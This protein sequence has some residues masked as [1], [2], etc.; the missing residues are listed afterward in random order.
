MI[1]F[2]TATFQYDLSNT[3]ISLAE[4]NDIFNDDIDRNYTLPFAIKGDAELLTKLGIPTLENISD[5]DTKI[6]GRLIVGDNHYPATL[7]L[8]QIT[9]KIIECNITFGEENISTYDTDLKDL[10]WP[11]NVAADILTFARSKSQSN[12]PY[13]AFAFPMIYRPE[14]SKETNYDLFEGFVNNY[15]NG[16]YLGNE[17][18]T[19]GPEPV[20]INRNVLAPCPY[21]LEILKFGFK[22]AG[23]KVIGDIFKDEVLKKAVYIPQN[24][25]E[26]FRGSEYVNFSFGMPTSTEVV[27]NRIVYG[28]YEKKI[29]PLSQGTY[30]IDYNINLD[31]VLARYF[32]F[33]IFRE[34]SLSQERTILFQALSKDNRVTLDEKFSVNVEELDN[35]SPIIIQ[36]KILQTNQSITDFNNFEYS[37]KG[38]QLNEFPSVFTLSNFMPDQT[39]GEFVNE[40]K[41]WLNLDITPNERYVEI[42]FT[43]DSILKKPS[44]DHSHL[45][46]PDKKITHNSN[47]F[48]KLS[49][50]NK[51]QVFY[52]KNGQVYSDIDEEGNETVE[53]KMDV[54]PLAVERNKN[55]TTAVYPSKKSKIDFSVYD[56]FDANNLPTCS[57]SLSKTLSLDNVTKDRWKTWIYF[58]I[59]SKTFKENFECSVFENI[60]IAALSKKYNELHI[61][62]KLTRKILS[63]K[64]M[65]VDVESE[66][67]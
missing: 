44:V 55:I 63:E 51:E 4:Q 19:S 15:S 39:F 66:T 25:L 47:R 16:A 33:T 28:I 3:G 11:V 6:T 61:I 18:D 57:A 14:I 43:Q 67:F 10:P 50:A 22:T 17:V 8:G 56:G 37:F 7:F 12:W 41:N 31:P 58:R 65:K 48:Y 64:R 23:K 30:E 49:Y 20:Y 45:E 40:M 27:F 54:Q 59:N 53:I 34:D 1:I 32:E 35:F 13:S 36:L 2:Q 46:D 9:G 62:K 52:N 5:L 60:S 24:Y 21:L 38:G 42:N 29:T 26:K